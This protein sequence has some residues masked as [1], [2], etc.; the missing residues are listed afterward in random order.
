LKGILFYV[1]QKGMDLP[2]DK[3]QWDHPNAICEDE[4]CNS[5]QAN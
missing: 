5:D 1:G 2:E 4:N 3:L